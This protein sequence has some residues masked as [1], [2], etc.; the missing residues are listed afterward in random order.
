[1]KN[2]LKSLV[3]TIFLLVVLIIGGLG[4][5]GFIPFV[6]K[7]LGTSNPRDLGIKYSRADYDSYMVKSQ[8][9]IQMVSELPSA[10][11][12]IIYSGSV[13]QQ[14]SFTDEE[15][16]ARINDST[17]EYFPFK[18]MQM[19]FNTDGS[20]EFSALLQSGRIQGFISSIGG[21]DYSSAELDKGMEILTSMGVNPAFYAK[22]TPVAEDNDWT[23][24]AQSIELGRLPIPLDVV[25]A[26]ESLTKLTN[27]V[28]G[29]IPNLNVRS[30]SIEKGQMNLDATVPNEVSIKK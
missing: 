30:F 12:G 9:K 28:A 26:D 8:A 4:Y 7:L 11:P 6:S 24:S 16:T 3:I 2:F 1:M 22:V 10:A 20:L 25:R 19:K 17:W 14:Q 13:E 23:V 15:I 18:V 29:L 21:L 5:L 27:Y